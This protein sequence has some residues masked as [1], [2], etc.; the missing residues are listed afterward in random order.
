MSLPLCLDKQDNDN[1][2]DT[3]LALYTEQQIISKINM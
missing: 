1:D 2:Q 3:A